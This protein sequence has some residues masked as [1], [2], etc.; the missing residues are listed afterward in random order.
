[1]FQK[2]LDA[3]NGHKMNTG[4][5]LVILPP[6]MSQ[7][8]GISQDEAMRQ[9]NGVLAGLGAVIAIWGYIHKFV[10]GQAAK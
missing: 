9:V 1:M 5:M 10:K 2:I 3:M 4:V 6:I 7:V 8:F